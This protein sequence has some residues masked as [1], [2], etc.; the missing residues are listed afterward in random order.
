MKVI[1]ILVLLLL[2]DCNTVN[3]NNVKLCQFEFTNVDGRAFVFD[4]SVAKPSLVILVE[5]VYCFD[6]IK[7]LLFELKKHYLENSL[8][9]Y[10]IYQTEPSSLSKKYFLQKILP[11]SFS[12]VRFLFSNT[13]LFNDIFSYFNVKG[14]PS[15]VIFNKDDLSLLSYFPFERLFNRNGVLRE[16]IVDS[17]MLMIGSSH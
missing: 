2:V 17:L 4:S 8:Y 5:K 14:S 12:G 1:I 16:K 7:A 9:I 15:I 6:C 3:I 13:K 11:Y 10:L